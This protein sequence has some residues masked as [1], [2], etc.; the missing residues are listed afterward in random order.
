MNENDIIPDPYVVEIRLKRSWGT[1]SSIATSCTSC[2]NMETHDAIREMIGEEINQS[3]LQNIL[4]GKIDKV[5][6]HAPKSDD[7]QIDAMRLASEILNTY[8]E[9]LTSSELKGTEIVKITWDKLLQLIRDYPQLLKTK[10]FMMGGQK[11][12]LHETQ[13]AEL[14]KYA[15]ANQKIQAIKAIREWT[16]SSLKDAKSALENAVNGLILFV[17]F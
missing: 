7:H 8:R 13:W 1:D 6:I 14:N 11:Y 2:R 15:S 5:I 17:P 16:G 3:I 4:S 10:P 12:D 9:I